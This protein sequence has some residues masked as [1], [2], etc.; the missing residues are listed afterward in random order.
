[1]SEIASCCQEYLNIE[2]VNF[3]L[4]TSETQEIARLFLQKPPN[5][6]LATKEGAREFITQHFWLHAFH[7]KCQIKPQDKQEIDYIIEDTNFTWMDKISLC[8]CAPD[9]LQIYM[10]FP[11]GLIRGSFH[12]L[13]FNAQIIALNGGP[14]CHWNFKIITL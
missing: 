1:M 7:G 2:M 14:P 9:Q 8:G 3:F 13:G 6:F 10:A 11:C 12:Q 4:R 5:H